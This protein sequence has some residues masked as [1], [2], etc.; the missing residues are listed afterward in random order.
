MKKKISA[1]IFRHIIVPLVRAAFPKYQ[2]KNVENI[3]KEPCILVGN[4]SQMHG[5]VAAE[6]YMPRPR[7]TW[8]AGEMM[9]KDEVV[10][11]AYR[12]FWSQKPAWTHWFFKILAHLIKPIA[13]CIFNNAATLQVYH[14]VRVIDTYRLSMERLQEGSHIIIFPEKNEKY[15]HILY[16]FQDKFVDLARFYY[17]K[18]KVEL[19]F[20]PFYL[21]P[22]LK[23][24]TFGQPIHFHHETPIDEERKRI[25]QEIKD[26]ITSIAESQPLHTVIPYRNIPK[27]LYPKNIVSQGAKKQK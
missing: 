26:Q 15:N 11:Y 12:D 5:P 9:N 16:E 22:K 3:P 6:L 7:Y 14:D 1:F 24:L 20:V 19:D 25:I 21:A 23:T 2:L 13:L 4:H 27:H 8:C 10:E 17:R 18:Y